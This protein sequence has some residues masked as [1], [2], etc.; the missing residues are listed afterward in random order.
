M[1]TV[2]FKRLNEDAQLPKYKTAEA[3]GMDLVA[4]MPSMVTVQAGHRIL[5]PTGWAIALEKGFEAQVRARSGLSLRKG[6]TV[7]NGPGTIDS[8]FRG[9]LKVILINHG[10]HPVDIYPGDRVAQLIVAP[11]VQAEI[12]EVEELDSTERGSGGFGSTGS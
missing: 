12:Q 2:K 9:E 3:A 11:V 10:A 4:C 5:I 7:L 8:D 1:T 6:I